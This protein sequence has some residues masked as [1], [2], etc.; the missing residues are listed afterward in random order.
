MLICGVDAQWS[1]AGPGW[2][3][4]WSPNS[5]VQFPDQAAYAAKW[6][7]CPSAFGN[8]Q[9]LNPDDETCGHEAG[10]SSDYCTTPPVSPW[11]GWI[12]CVP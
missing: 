12:Q 8:L 7:K 6:G 3:G 11:V 10:E 5:S 1:A 9:Y 4:S 2:N